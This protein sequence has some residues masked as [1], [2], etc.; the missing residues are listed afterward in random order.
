M[1]K[2]LAPFLLPTPSLPLKRPPSWNSL[3]QRAK[4]EGVFPLFYENLLKQKEIKKK[5][6]PD[7]LQ[8]M[9]SYSYTLRSRQILFL[10]ELQNIVNGFEKSKIPF[11]LFKGFDLSQR[12]YNDLFLREQVDFDFIVDPKNFSQAQEGLVALG[13]E[14]S[15]PLK[16]DFF[17]GCLWV[18]IHRAILNI[19]RFEEE[20]T[21]TLCIEGMWERQTEI[22]IEDRK[23]PVLNLEDLFLAL[24]IHFAF[25]H[26]LRGLKWL[27]DLAWMLLG[28]KI[29]LEIVLARAGENNLEP[30]LW[31]TWKQLQTVYGLPV[32][33]EILIPRWQRL[34]LSFFGTL[35]VAPFRYLFRLSLLPKGV[36]LQKLFHDFSWDLKQKTQFLKD[37]FIALETRWTKVREKISGVETFKSVSL[38]EL[39]IEETKGN[40]YAPTAYSELKK[41]F[42][43]LPITSNDVFLDL[44]SGKGRVLLLAGRYPF[45]KMIGV[46]IA[47]ALNQVARDNLQKIGG[48]W[49]GCEISLVTA[50]ARN[51]EI[52]GDVTMIYCH[53][54]LTWDGL[55]KTLSNIQKSLERTPRPLTFIYNNPVYEKELQQYPWIRKIYE[56]KLE[57][58]DISYF[59]Y[60]IYKMDSGT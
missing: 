38:A 42:R 28:K 58:G 39:G 19:Q 43:R 55:E 29:S 7:L 18:E 11:L 40:M 13:Y 49:K 21:K 8:E 52:P 24:S 25:H 27:T 23:I 36:R 4:Q 6:H 47:E 2:K 10:E 20:G 46:D 35:N 9:K 1:E 37:A 15:D 54:S 57:Y 50:D 16:M 31:S 14:W 5:I 59:C 33:R 26:H 30:V 41:I 17:K 12:I 45:K 22:L 60:S 34:W 56:Y 32:P 3:F 48:R 53:N 51:F 44:G